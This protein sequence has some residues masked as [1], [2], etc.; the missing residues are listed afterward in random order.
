VRSGEAAEHDQV[1]LSGVTPRT[2]GDAGRRGRHGTVVLVRPGDVPLADPGALDDPL[3]IGVQP[4]GGE[5]GI[6]Q[7]T[8]RRT[9][10]DPGE[11]DERSL[12][13]LTPDSPAAANVPDGQAQPPSHR[14]LSARRRLAAQ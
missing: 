5:L 14:V 7:D 11:I 12:H 3:V 6:P 8:I 9:P 10:A 2:H 13:A 1:D 4:H